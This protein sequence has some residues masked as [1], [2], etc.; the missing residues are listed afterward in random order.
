MEW[1]VND[2][3]DLIRRI[4]ES[5][6]EHLTKNCATAMLDAVIE[7]GE[8]DNDYI[9]TTRAIK[10]TLRETTDGIRQTIEGYANKQS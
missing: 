4:E 5:Q 6:K 3:L 10:H 7:G 9:V 1:I 2:L 8:Y